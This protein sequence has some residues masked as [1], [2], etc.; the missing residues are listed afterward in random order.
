MMLRNMLT[1]VSM[2]QPRD[3]PID[4]RSK[5]LILAFFNSVYVTYF[6]FY[7]VD[8]IGCFHFHLLAEC[9][10]CKCYRE[11]CKGSVK[12]VNF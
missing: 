9:I 8:I 3:L 12:R 6:V 7:R 1:A 5:E 4:R 2:W 11:V 10:E